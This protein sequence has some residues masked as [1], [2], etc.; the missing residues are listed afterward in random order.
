MVNHRM[1]IY[2]RVFIFGINLY[3]TI[4]VRVHSM[5]IVGSFANF[6]VS[7]IFNF[8]I[9]LLK[10]HDKSKLDSV[11]QIIIMNFELLN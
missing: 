9:L 3:S 1:I 2:Y 10:K 5:N 4:A 11:R 8:K 6:H 7:W